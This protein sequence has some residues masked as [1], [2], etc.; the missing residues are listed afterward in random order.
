MIDHREPFAMMQSKVHLRSLLASL[1]DRFSGPLLFL[2]YIDNVHPCL[3]YAKLTLFA[4]DMEIYYSSSNS[5]ILEKDADLQNVLH[6]LTKNKLILNEDK[7]KLMIF[8][9]KLKLCHFRNVQLLV[10]DSEIEH[11]I[12]FTVSPYSSLKS[13][14]HTFQ[15][16]CLV[17]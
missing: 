3:E 6:W 14:K 16:Q 17:H 11:V 7:S 5:S 13:R 9:K 1:K 15:I 2:V 10:G 12:N 4:D 8:G